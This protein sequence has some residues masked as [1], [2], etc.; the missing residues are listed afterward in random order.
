MATIIGA[1][2]TAAE[3]M[4]LY[5]THFAGT[6]AKVVKALKACLDRKGE[7]PVDGWVPELADE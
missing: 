7:G 4:E 1:A 5:A 3:A 6:G 2:Q